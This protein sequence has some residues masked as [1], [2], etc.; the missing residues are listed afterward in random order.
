MPQFDITTKPN[1]YPAGQITAT[2]QGWVYTNPLTGQSEVI[3]CIRGLNT[4]NTDAVVAPAW[5][6]TLMANGTYTVGQT[7]VLT[8][9]PNEA[10]TVSG[11][12]Y[13]DVTIGAIVRRFIYDGTTSTDT[14]L[15]FNYTLVAGDADADGI[16]VSNT[17][18]KGTGKIFDQAGTNL[19]AVAGSIT[20]TVGSTVAI[21]VA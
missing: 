20:Y 1:H 18:T 9:V 5:T 21:L 12:P 6:L 10:V 8:L 2:A 15:K 13:I 4:K 16:T 19:S 3:A 7:M 17:L 14:S 11:K